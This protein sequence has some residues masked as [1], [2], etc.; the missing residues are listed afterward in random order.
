MPKAPKTPKT[1]TTPAATAVKP[2]VPTDAA[3]AFAEIEPTLAALS[4]EQFIPINVDIPRAVAIA[5]GAVP[6]LAKLREAAA[7]L[8]D[9]DV[10]D[11]DRIGTY[12]LAAWYAH[13]LALPETTESALTALLDEAKPL[14]E[15]LLV[16]AE[17][18]AHKKIFDR[19][20]VKAIRAGQGNIDTANDLVALAALYSMSWARVENST[21]VEWPEV[22][23]AAV[24]GPQI[25]VA[26]GQRD[27]PGVPM[28]DATSPAERRVRAYTVFYKAYDQC[29]RAA[30]YLR[31]A[32][33]DA[34]TFAPALQTGR[35]AR[36]GSTASEEDAT[37]AEPM[38]PDATSPAAPLPPT[39]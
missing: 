35:N 22:E 17:A 32:E 5:I 8:P 16:A 10:T 28:S 4:P 1:P 21:T 20:A 33:D 12:A 14:R 25:L 9:F 34:D 37:D 7:K 26:L 24:L 11:L 2:G 39:K 18:L 19:A 36:R 13:L 30:A 15:D 31:W 3:K 29:R 6:H 27:Q 23:R 38:A